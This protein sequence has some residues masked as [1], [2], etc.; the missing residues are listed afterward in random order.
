M[1]KKILTLL[2]SVFIFMLS[3]VLN[4]TAI[5]EKG[6]YYQSENIPI[7]ITEYATNVFESLSADVLK[8]IGLDCNDVN[9]YLIS[10]GIKVNYLDDSNDDKYYFPILYHD[11]IVA[12]LTVDKLYNELSFSLG[13]NN[14]SK[15][16]NELKFD[17]NDA[18]S[19][20][21]LNNTVYFK[22]TQ[23]IDKVYEDSS[24]IK[25]NI[26]NIDI[27]EKID[28]NKCYESLN[29]VNINNTLNAHI[30]ENQSFKLYSII[31]A[32]LSLDNLP[33]VNNVT[34][35]GVGQCW[36]ASLGS[37][38]EYLKDGYNSSVSKGR[39]IRDNILNNYVTAYPENRIIKDYTGIDLK[40]TNSMFS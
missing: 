3:G 8:N 20:Y 26:D 32:G 28:S 18:N 30:K 16:L 31:R 22:N 7:D 2:F 33:C 13:V 24:N 29:I 34:I 11:S 25:N 27:L 21:I 36:A 23:R 19:I 12:L 4:V 9:D 6:R 17:K 39:E 14:I 38:I 1:S 37:T 15:L 40:E 10:S 5:E 35:N